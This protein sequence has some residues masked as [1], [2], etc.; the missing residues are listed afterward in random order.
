MYNWTID[1]KKL[2]KSPKEATIWKLQQAINFG[3]NGKKLN[4][5][6]IKR[7]WKELHL[8][9]VRRKFLKFLLWSKRS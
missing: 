4:K 2:A 9:P 1:L 3:L 8:D 5:R 7:Y 6:L